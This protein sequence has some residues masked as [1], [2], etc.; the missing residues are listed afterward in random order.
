M[1]NVPTI[2]NRYS[3]SGVP[4]LYYD[5]TDWKSYRF[6]PELPEPRHS[7]DGSPDCQ[8]DVKW[9][10]RF[11][12]GTQQATTGWAGENAASFQ[13]RN[14]QSVHSARALCKNDRPEPPGSFPSAILQVALLARPASPS[15]MVKDSPAAHLQQI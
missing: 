14:A 12:S 6:L 2:S 1:G 5:T 11:R 7:H 15:G 8:G 9:S 10:R 4:N 3:L 13:A